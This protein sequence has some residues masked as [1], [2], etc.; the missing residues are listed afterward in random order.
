M[1]PNRIGYAIF[2]DLR[3][4]CLEL[5]ADDRSVQSYQFKVL[6][7]YFDY[8]SL[9]LFLEKNDHWTIARLIVKVGRAEFLESVLEWNPAD[10]QTKVSFYGYL[11][12]QA[13]IDRDWGDQVW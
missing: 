1:Y 8:A 7:Q 11:G 9:L 4:E 5:C 10:E 3:I 2:G 12:H 6:Q 13:N